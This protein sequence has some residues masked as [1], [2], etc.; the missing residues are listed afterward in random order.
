MKRIYRDEANGKVAGICAGIGE[1]LSV[2]PTVVRLVVVF[3]A[4]ATT[5]WPA[6]LT[7]V[8]GWIIIPDKSELA[9]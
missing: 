7:Y 2:D 5:F 1:M 3:L 6:V 9:D 8:A 4:V